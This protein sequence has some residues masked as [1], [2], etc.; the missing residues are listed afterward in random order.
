MKHQVLSDLADMLTPV[1]QVKPKPGNA[2]RHDLEDLKHSLTVNGQYRP[3]IANRRTGHIVK[4]NGTYAAAVALGW[5]SLAVSWIDDDEQ[6]ET[7]MTLVDNRTTELGWMNDALLAQALRTKEDLTGTGYVPED[8]DYL[9]R[10]LSGGLDLLPAAPSDRGAAMRDAKAAYDNSDARQ[11]V[12]VV[13][14]GEYDQLMAD[15][16]SLALPGENIALV[17]KRLVMGSLGP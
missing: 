12:L 7:R 9:D 11:L 6:G 10:T 15:L 8:L 16:D 13:M 3:I 14:A 5:D 4:G 17:V 1:G 2:R